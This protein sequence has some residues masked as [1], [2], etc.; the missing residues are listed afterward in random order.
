MATALVNPDFVAL[1]QA[2]G[3]AAFRVA[4]TAEFG[5]ALALAR[6]HAGPALI[7][8]VTSIEDIAPGRRL[9]PANR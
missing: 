7:E 5:A 9:G 3:L 2:Y 8:L 4:A 1:A 6:E